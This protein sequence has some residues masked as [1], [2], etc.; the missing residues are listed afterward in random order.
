M[1]QW[2]FLDFIAD[3]ARRYPTF[4]LKMHAEVTDL[5][6]DGGQVVGVRATTP[7]GPLEVRAELTFGTDGRHSTV[8]DR[9]GLPVEDVGAPMDVLWMRLSRAPG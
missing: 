6:R 1:P 5:L 9:A 8:R 4:Q 7:E 3:H 2:D